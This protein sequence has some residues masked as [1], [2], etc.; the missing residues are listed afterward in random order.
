MK[1]HSLEEGSNKIKSNGINADGIRSNLHSNKVIKSRSK[2]RGLTE[3]EY[4]SGNLLKIEVKLIDLAKAF[5]SLALMEKN[6]W[7]FIDC[8]WGKY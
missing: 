6:Y 3:D 2:A 8:R 7:S 1:Q 5:L 4:M